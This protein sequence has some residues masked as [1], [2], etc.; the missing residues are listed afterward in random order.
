MHGLVSNILAIFPAL[1]FAADTTTGTETQTRVE[2]LRFVT[3][4]RTGIEAVVD[5]THFS[6]LI[7]SA[8]AKGNFTVYNF[9]DTWVGN[10]TGTSVLYLNNVTGTCT[11]KNTSEGNGWGVS[12]DLLFWPKHPNKSKQPSES[13]TIASGYYGSTL[14]IGHVKVHKG[15]IAEN[16]SAILFDGKEPNLDSVDA[17]MVYD[18]NDKGD[19]GLASLLGYIA[20]QTELFTLSDNPAGIEYITGDAREVL[21]Q[22][23]LVQVNVTSVDMEQRI[24][25]GKYNGSELKWEVGMPVFYDSSRM[26]TDRSMDNGLWLNS[27]VPLEPVGNITYAD[28]E[29]LTILAKYSCLPSNLTHYLP[30]LLIPVSRNTISKVDSLVEAAKANGLAAAAAATGDSEVLTRFNGLIT[31]R[32]PRAKRHELRS[33]KLLVE[34]DIGSQPTDDKVHL[35]EPNSITSTASTLESPP[36]LGHL[37]LQVVNNASLISLSQPITA[38]QNITDGT[39]VT[40]ITQQRHGLLMNRT[41]QLPAT[42]DNSTNYLNEGAKVLMHLVVTGH[43]WA[44]TEEQCG[45]YCHAVY[46]ISLNGNSAANVT[47]F[48]DDCKDNPIGPPQYGTWDES[49]NGWCPGTVNPG[50]FMDLTHHMRPGSNTLSIDLVVWSNATLQYEPYTDFAGF[51]YGDGANLIVNLN[52]FVYNS[53]TVSTIVEQARPRTPAEK[54]VIFGC[55]APSRLS[56]PEFVHEPVLQDVFLQT[57]SNPTKHKHQHPRSSSRHIQYFNQLSGEGLTYMGKH[58]K[59]PMN[60][61]VVMWEDE[62]AEAAKPVPPPHGR[63]RTARAVIRAEGA[64]SKQ[65]DIHEHRSLGAGSA[66]ISSDAEV[67][68]MPMGFDFEGRAPW[69]LYNTSKE[70]P[71]QAFRFPVFDSRLQQGNTR[72]VEQ[73]LVNASSFPDWG[74]VAVHFRLHDPPLP[75]PLHIDHWDRVGSLGL[76]L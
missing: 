67:D 76:V 16:G 70:G 25:Y 12:V 35:L 1:A 44:A 36:L 61:A 26:F 68:Q 21:L 43:G 14:A 52:A 31:A 22:S 20:E 45:E 49:R 28:G 4:Y 73:L 13:I 72:H 40:V 46:R 7:R 17:G 10:G 65:S 33:P 66:Q 56:P 18:M 38:D 42:L 47:Q 27:S 53:S 59:P 5:L 32:L 2:L 58:F 54:A 3:A 24:V 62:D 50:L 63:M 15:S 30:H 64:T 37:N 71:I 60:R 41:F 74:H 29:N 23:H 55:N 39:P 19:V 48:R 9:I 6:P 11:S 57:G 34:S 51:I 75:R 8:V 69:F